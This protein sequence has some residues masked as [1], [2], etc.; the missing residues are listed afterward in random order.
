MVRQHRPGKLQPKYRGP[1]RVSRPASN[2]F[3]SYIIFDSHGEEFVHSFHA[4]DLK[5]FEPRKDYISREED[6]PIHWRDQTIRASRTKNKKK[7][8]KNETRKKQK[9]KPFYF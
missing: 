1:F 4:N 2:R 9:K 3:V 7:K 8:M 5:P 6:D